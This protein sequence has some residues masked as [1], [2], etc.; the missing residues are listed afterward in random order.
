MSIRRNHEVVATDDFR[1]FHDK[2]R[3]FENVKIRL[4]IEEDDAMNLPLERLPS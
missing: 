2:Y 4:T 3:I 1:E